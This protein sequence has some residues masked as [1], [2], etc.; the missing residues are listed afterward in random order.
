[1]RRT[2]TLLDR[3]GAELVAEGLVAAPPSRD[4]LVRWIDI[5]S[6]TAGA[7]VEPDRGID[8]ERVRSEWL[9]DYERC[10]VE[11]YDHLFPAGHA[12]RRTPLL[13]ALD[14]RLARRHPDAGATVS[15]V[16]RKRP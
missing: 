3:V 11:S 4:E 9:P 5:H 6:P 12:A 14:R 10:H 13:R 2:E 8:V 7:E 1:V 15:F 16:L